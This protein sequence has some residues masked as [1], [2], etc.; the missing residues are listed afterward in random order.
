MKHGHA[1]RGHESREYRSWSHMI[2]RCEDVKHPHFARYGG[3]GIT[4]CSRWRA[5]FEAFLYDM[6][7]RPEGT[8]LDRFPDPD[9]NYEPGNCR[10]GTARDQHRNTSATK[11]TI[12]LVLEIHGRVEHGESLASVAR[13]LKVSPGH[14]SDVRAGKKWSEYR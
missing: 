4:V 10:W 5:S 1:R 3:R 7:P 6:G 11:L 14:V 12:G 8:S 2:N 13:R 9:G